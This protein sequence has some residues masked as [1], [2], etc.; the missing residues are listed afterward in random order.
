MGHE[1]S[2]ED[3]DEDE[4]KEGRSADAPACG[5]SIPERGQNGA[6]WEEGKKGWK[7]R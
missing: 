5:T 1:D 2:K 4:D 6:R 3:E 7:G